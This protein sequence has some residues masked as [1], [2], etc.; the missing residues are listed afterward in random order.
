MNIHTLKP[1]ALAALASGLGSFSALAATVTL[2][3]DD[4]FGNSS[5]NS[6]GFW[7]NG[8]APSAGNDYF[9]GQFRLRTPADGNSYTF[10]GNSLVA[11]NAPIQDGSA[12]IG[13]KGAGTTAILTANWVLDGGQAFNLQDVSTVFRMGG[14]L[15]ITPNGGQLWAKQGDI[16]VHAPISGTGPL[17]IAQTD[18]AGE[19]TR[20]FV[21]LFGNNTAFTGPITLFGKLGIVSEENLGGNPATFT[22][23]QLMFDGGILGV[24]NSVVINDSNRGLTIVSSGTIS[25]AN[26]D[27]ETVAELT[28]ASPI[29]GG[30]L[31]KTGNGVLTLSGNNEFAGTLSVSAGQLNLNSSTALGYASLTL[32][33][34]TVLDS[35]GGANVTLAN[36]NSQTWNGNFTFLGT[37]NLSFAQG[38]VIMN[39][40]VS[41]TVSNGTLTV[42]PVYDD[43]G[44]R[45]LT[46][47]G[48]GT[49]VIDGGIGISG[50]TVV[51]D[52]TLT[53]L[54]SSY[55][56]GTTINVSSNGTLN[57]ASSGFN[58]N[59]A[60]ILT[61]SGTV[62]GAVTDSYGS[63]IDP[64]NGI[65]T[66]TINGSLNLSGNGAISFQ[67]S[68]DTTPGAGMNDLVVVTGQLNVTGPTTLNL[69]G[70]PATGTYTLFQ[71]GSFSGSTAN[72]VVPPGYSINNN[73]TAKTIELI[74]THVPVALTWQGDDSANVW[75]LGVTAN[76]RQ[77][78]SP[79]VFLTGDS[80]TFDNSGSVWPAVQIVGELSPASVTVNSSQNYTFSGGSLIAG[81]L[82][83]NG[84]G[85]LILD[86]TN[87]YLGPTLINQG[88][89]QVGDPFSPTSGG[90]V[91]TLGRG[92]VTNNA[93]L[94]FNR[95]GTLTITNG[96]HGAGVITN[97]GGSTILG[98]SNSYSGVTVIEGGSITADNYFALGSTN[99][100][101]IVQGFGQLNA[102]VN[103]TIDENLILNPLDISTPA[104]RNGGNQT[105]VINGTVA[106]VSST[107]IQVDNGSTMVFSNQVSG[108]GELIKNQGGTLVLAGS[109]T[110]TGGLSFS[111][112]TV[113]LANSNALGGSQITMTSTAG[114]PGLSGSR[115]TVSGGSII[116]GSKSLSMPSSGNGTVRSALVGGAGTN[117]WTG[118]ITITGDYDPG[119]QIGF[120]ADANATFIIAGNVTADPSFIGKINIRGNATGVGILSG[121]VTL[122]PEGQIQVDDGATW[123]VASTGNT[124]G[125]NRI[126]SG[127][128]QL[129]A[130]N[131]LPVASV[132]TDGSRFDLAGFNQTI[133]GL[134]ASV[135][136][137]NSSEVADSTLTY[138]G[139]PS[140][141]TGS[142]RE[143]ARKLNLN[144]AS[145]TLTLTSANTL[146]SPRSTVS[147]ASGAVLDLSYIGTNRVA[148][149]ILNG[150]VQEPG[151][152]SSATS[153]PFLIGSGVIEVANPIPTTPTTITVGVTG[154]T[155][156]LSWP[157]SHAGWILQV[158]TNSLA[159]GLGS[160]WTDVPGSASITST[161]I[162]VDPAAPATFFRLR[163]P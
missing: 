115:V 45:T 4:A 72:L 22:P 19:T 78:G 49:L 10:G 157:D 67:L 113:N 14:T 127:T 53:I 36:Y 147:V 27:A 149:L 42:G 32:S 80:V 162:T 51:N 75:D 21:Y 122:A 55:L 76:W 39:G 37:R 125:T 151:F 89:L 118:P 2:T 154:N 25:V 135:T 40:N 20:R 69:L 106:L 50:N 91:G 28:I 101:T 79:S 26:P 48:P 137:T 47:E 95:I 57:V 163:A 143:G 84:T 126:V 94:L 92:A 102:W 155:L 68:P 77:N 130:N 119:N 35:T 96:I 59:G 139:G 104:I 33:G 13:Y 159:T 133:A 30:S 109:N 150:V 29:T 86:N 134:N 1:L 15:S 73:T 145:G 110:F 60:Q 93:T 38:S 160:N 82:T 88:T 56:S 41:V 9:T 114:G 144:I 63:T 116:P 61:G 31:S 85:T 136:I 52:G 120:G 6:A 44:L 17:T 105:F 97:L 5:F 62:V 100:P 138:A 83:K 121:I 74:V 34:G 124:W 141:F 148:G 43:G 54:N 66:L 142:I 132:I 129:G 90:S 117:A 11:N 8:A 7:D 161:N 107:S 158:Q 108:S 12:G 123:V 58:L 23:D 131:A 152:Y 98:G 70:S 111:A 64:G 65:G 24:T 140:T 46:K 112:G 128:L 99:S 81:S 153:S 146:S 87:S 3:G 103:R 71:Y 16:V 18:A 156:S